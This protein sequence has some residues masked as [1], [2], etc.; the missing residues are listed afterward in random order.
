VEPSELETS[1][2]DVK[3]T[4]AIGRYEILGTLG[5]GNMGEV[6]LA[7]D[8]MIGRMVALKTRRFDL[9]YDEKDLKFVVNRFFE[10]ARI[11]GN[12]IH[13]NIVTIFD[14]GQDGDYCFIAMEL[15]EGPSLASYNKQETLLPAA[16]VADMI[17]RVCLGLHFAHSHNVIHRDIKP[18][19]LMF[20]SDRRMKITD[21]GIAML[22]RTE[23][24]AELQVMGT[25]SYMSPEQTKGLQLTQQTDFFSLGVVFFELLAGR[26]PFQGRTLYDLMESIRYS[27][28]PSVLAYNPKLP[29]GLDQVIHRA[30]EKEP[31][32]R[33]RSGKEFA[34][35][36]ELAMKGRRIR[37]QDDKAERK[38][39]L[40]KPIDFFRSFSLK[41][42]GEVIRFG[43]FIR[44]DKAQ[45]ILREG[46]VDTTFFILLSGTVR[47][48]KDSR[49]I[50]DLQTGACF[51]EMGAFTETS[52]TAHVV[53]RESC[54]VL[55]IDLKVLERSSP[56][57]RLKV[58]Q[59]FIETLI[60]RLDD[61][62]QRLSR[63][64]RVRQPKETAESHN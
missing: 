13:P 32:L 49:K 18:A 61:T 8:P 24:S 37:G 17:R 36:I 44:Y 9:V 57:L 59:V 48:F 25:P 2:S 50:A 58:Y 19:N 55:K 4:S 56:A 40:L 31:E 52:R 20:T 22:V 51:G 12:L 10:E 54:I 42:I 64:S 38:A 29:A 15:L 35:D 23:Q 60:K 43:T 47:V 63:E 30:L 62:T 21:F 1:S 14:V 41:E 6:F 34:M 16:K 11:A 3:G 5:R 39:E 7:R 53:A 33:Y 27:P 28:T 46:D 45:V 26:R